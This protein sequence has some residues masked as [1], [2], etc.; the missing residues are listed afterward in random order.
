MASPYANEWLESAKEEVATQLKKGVFRITQPPPGQKII[1]GQWV[2]KI[3]ENPDGTV[4][5]FKARWVAKGYTQ[6]KGRDYNKTYAP[7]VRSDTS[8]MLLA[9][10]AR[11][12]WHIHQYDIVTAYLNSKVNRML[13]TLIPKGFDPNDGT[14]CLLNNALYGLVQSAYLWFKEI[15]STFL[16]MG[17]IQSKFDDALF[18]DPTREL[19]IT[20]Y[21]DDI[22]A[23]SPIKEEIDRFYKELSAKY[24]AKDL[25]EVNFYVGM[26]INR[27]HD[28]SILLTQRKYIKDLLARHDMEQCAPANTPMIVGQLT[29]APEGYKCDAKEL[30]N[31]QTLTGELMH[32]MVQTRPD[33]AQAIS[34]CAQYMSNPTNKH[35]IALKRIL[36]YL[37]G[38]QTLGICHSKN[39]G[40][41]YL[42]MWTDSSWGEDFDHLRSTNGYVAIMAGGPVVWKSSKQTSV[43]LSSTEAEY[44]G[45]TLAATHTDGRNY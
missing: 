44:M 2:F 39:I 10:S 12:G 13:Y 1:E 41:L 8:R 3:K 40:S 18:Y 5:K 6:V 21:V 29:K 37:Q 20:I 4:A 33:I 16:A 43:A 11:K 26:E 17:L 32:F 36:R 42:E 15:K 34:Q 24:K 9:I 7:V 35:W 45:Q 14:V 30:K 38:S 28:G 25:G 19:Y 27:L 23:F 22:K 31:Y